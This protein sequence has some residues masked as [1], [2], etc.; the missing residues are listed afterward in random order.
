MG[1]SER[2]CRSSGVGALKLATAKQSQEAAHLGSFHPLRWTRA[3]V[4]R[5][6]HVSVTF[7]RFE[8]LGVSNCRPPS[9]SSQGKGKQT[10]VPIYYEFIINISGFLLGLVT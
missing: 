9:A 3:P 8:S 4:S 6:S 7:S 1:R 10:F 2:C 5:A